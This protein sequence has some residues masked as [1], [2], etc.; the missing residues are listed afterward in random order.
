MTKT[1]DDNSIRIKLSTFWNLK[2][3]KKEFSTQI[4]ALQRFTGISNRG[5]L[6]QMNTNAMQIKKFIVYSQNSLS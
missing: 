2:I 1:D 3:V 4:N 5:L 6:L